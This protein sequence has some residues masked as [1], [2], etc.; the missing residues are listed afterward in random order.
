MNLMS[1]R[2]DDGLTKS[3]RYYRKHLAGTGAAREQSREWRAANP[4]R[5]RELCR[6]YYARHLEKERARKLARPRPKTD[7]VR[8]YDRNNKAMR[9]ASTPKGDALTLAE[10]RA[11]CES[12]GNRCAYCRAAAPLTQDHVTPVS[13][14]GLHVAANVVPACRPCNSSKKDREAPVHRGA[15][16]EAK[17]SLGT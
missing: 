13:R 10:W 6:D 1:A 4:E 9:R 8:E 2:I 3:Q 11:I 7:A 16:T 12:Y 15:G 14:G 17:N 5:S